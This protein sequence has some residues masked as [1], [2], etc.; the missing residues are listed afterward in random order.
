MTVIGAAVAVLARRA[1]ELRH[2]QDHDVGHPVAEVGDERG[3]RPREIVEAIRELARRAALIH[4][5]VP[6]ADVGERDLEPD[7]RLDQLRDLP[8]ALPERRARILGAV[9][10]QVLLRIRRA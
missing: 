4:V 10:R 6:A 2:R 9:P 7:V 8:Q 1:S 5:R 3:D